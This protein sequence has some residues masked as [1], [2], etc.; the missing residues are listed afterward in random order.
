MGAVTRQG[1]I[2][3]V[4][5]KGL[6]IEQ[7]FDDFLTKVFAD[8]ARFDISVDWAGGMEVLLG[9]ARWKMEV[10]EGGST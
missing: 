10:G 3:G 1:S 4:L 9:A 6:R 7:A 2:Q 5:K 8:R